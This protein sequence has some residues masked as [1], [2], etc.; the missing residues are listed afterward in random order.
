MPACNGRRG[1]VKRERKRA[2]GPHSWLQHL[3]PSLSPS[4]KG[5][6]EPELPPGGRAQRAP[7]TITRLPVCDLPRREKRG[8]LA[9][10]W[11]A[12][13]QDALSVQHETRPAVILPSLCLTGLNGIPWTWQDLELGAAT[14]QKLPIDA[15]RHT[16]PPTLL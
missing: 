8:L 9:C 11:P 16:V 12:L 10:L 5:S 3:S 14:V 7:D 6:R 2:E 15:H 1:V 4:P 13:S